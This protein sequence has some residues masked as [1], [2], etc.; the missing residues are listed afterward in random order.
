MRVIFIYSWIRK[1]HRIVDVRS[2]RGRMHRSR[3]VF[4]LI[5]LLVFIQTR[6]K[7][8]KSL[9]D[10]VDDLKE[11]KKFL[12]TKTNLLVIFTKSENAASKLM[13]MFD[14]VA[15]DIKGKGSL[16]IVDCR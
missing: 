7:K 10:S 16:A 14:G 12:R 13:P 5:L 9:I 15:E 8:G 3:L 1:L 6:A 2:E 11:F 4:V